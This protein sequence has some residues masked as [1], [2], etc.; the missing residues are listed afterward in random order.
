MEKFKKIE[1]YTN[2]LF[3]VLILASTAC[4]AHIHQ[5]GMLSPKAT[6]YLLKSTASA[7]FVLCGA[8]NLFMLL[9]YHKSEGSWKGWV[10]FAGLVFAM[11]GDIFLIDFFVLG[12]GLF[13]VGHIFFLV[14][15]CLIQKYSLLDILLTVGL[16][17]P[18]ILL[19]CLYPNFSFDGML[20]L[21]I[22]Y[23]LVISCMLAKGIGNYIVKRNTSSLIT[24]LGAILFFLSDLM[25]L[26][27]VFGGNILV[28]DMICLYTYY[29]AEFLLGISVLLNKNNYSKTAV[30]NIPTTN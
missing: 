15:F 13:A 24:M 6:Q 2:I 22:V 14:Y 30:K 25:L 5:L 12:A 23:A 1:L 11:A 9:K 4:Y 29:P 7:L 27:Y 16:I 10:L 17:I 21:V 20:P 26:F 28:F 18:S 19:I 3:G 8:F